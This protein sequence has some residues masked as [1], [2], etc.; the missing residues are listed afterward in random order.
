MSKIED[1]NIHGEKKKVKKGRIRPKWVKQLKC[2]KNPTKTKKGKT[3][4]KR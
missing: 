4:K 3:F 1:L 2:R